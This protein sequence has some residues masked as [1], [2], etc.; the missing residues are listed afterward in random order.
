MEIQ[1]VS[2]LAIV[3]V[4]ISMLLSVG[5]PI[6]LLIV[7]KK[8]YH[9]KISS[10]F[11]GAGTFL[12]FAMVLEQ[13]L[14]LLVIR[15][16][17]LNEQSNRWL[18]YIYAAAAAAVF[19]ET[20]R[21]IAMKFWMKKRLDFANGLMYGIGHGGCEAIMIG[22]LANINNLISMLMI[23]S[24]AMQQSL[25]LLP[26]ELKNQTLEQLSALWTTPTSLF[27]ASG[28]E[29]IVA[30]LLQIGLSLMI[31]KAVRT[32]KWGMAAIA[33]VLHFAVDFVAVAGANYCS[34]W[35]MEV[36]IF[37]AAI[38][39]LFLSLQINKQV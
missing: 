27:F 20:G 1:N 34:V 18:Y 31:Y 24:G 2:N 21:L 33:Y 11:I 36:F 19:E 6:A 13:I 23:N 38:G 3:G 25:A 39:T 30:L 22:G 5:V 4:L 9:A 37:V 16:G 17:G 26:D 32:K 35:I 8:K 10:F 29:R 7:G 14:H 15:V 28:I 12:L